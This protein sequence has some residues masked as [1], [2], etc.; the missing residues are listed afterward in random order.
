MWRV[1]VRAAFAT[2][3]YTLYFFFFPGLDG[4]PL[5][6]TPSTKMAC[7]GQTGTFL[8]HGKLRLC[9][10]QLHNWGSLNIVTDG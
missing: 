3:S 10:N 4:L 6:T 9:P 8:V 1:I 2:R 5:P 7:A